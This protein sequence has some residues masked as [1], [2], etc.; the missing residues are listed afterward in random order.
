M[1]VVTFL[2]ETQQPVLATSF[3]GDPNSDVSYPYLPGSMIRGALI[4]RYLK[5]NQQLGED[6]LS[7]TNNN[8]EVKRLFFDGNT[9]YLNAYLFCKKHKKRAL[10]VPLCWY[11]NKD[12]ELPKPEATSYLDVYNLSEFEPEE[13]SLKTLSEK[14][15]IVTE[16]QVVLYRERRRINIHTA[17][18]RQKGRSSP[19]KRDTATNKIIQKG[20]GAIFRYE[21]LDVQQ[22]FQGIILCEDQ[23]VNIIQKLLKPRDIWLGGSRSAGY[24]HTKI[25]DVNEPKDLTSW[26]EIDIETQRR[27]NHKKLVITFLSDTLIQDECG[28]FSAN[29]N[30]VT[31]AIEKKL[32]NQIKLSQLTSCFIK[33]IVVGGFNQKWGLPLPQMLGFSAGSVFIFDNQLTE[34]QIQTLEQEGIGDRCIEGFGRV[35]INWLGEYQEL[36]ARPPEPILIEQTELEKKYHD[37]AI[38]MAKNI[39]RQKLDKALIDKVGNIKLQGIITNNQLSRLEMAARQGLTNPPSFDPI[40]KLLSN[41]TSS[42][43][44]QY[45]HT[46]IFSSKSFKKQIEDWLKPENFWINNPQDFEVNIAAGVPPQTIEPNSNLAQE[47]T[48]RLLMAIAK[49]AKKETSQ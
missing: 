38:Q 31:Q 41:L 16:R 7:E 22:I 1:K 23:D 18:D 14:F 21:S 46:K 19:T 32:N 11:K 29:P 20:E 45:R 2:L 12:E 36:S 49:K 13:I 4:S 8:Q 47:Y 34:K 42:A 40:E 26:N 6:I 33:S 15:C 43:R 10:P 25:L 37:V 48:L 3:Q 44:E 5:S 9:R 27:L 39:L 17:R 24:G 35:A 28:Q 30:A